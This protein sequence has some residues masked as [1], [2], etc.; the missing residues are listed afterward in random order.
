MVDCMSGAWELN[1]IDAF[2][3]AVRL[4]W[5]KVNAAVANS[6]ISLFPAHYERVLTMLW[7]VAH[8]RSDAWN[9]ENPEE[10]LHQLS[11]QCK[12]QYKALANFIRS[13]SWALTFNVPSGAARRQFRILCDALGLYHRVL[14]NELATDLIRIKVYKE[15]LKERYERRDIIDPPGLEDLLTQHRFHDHDSPMR[16]SVLASEWVDAAM[17]LCSAKPDMAATILTRIF[18]KVSN[19]GL[20]NASWALEWSKVLSRIDASVIPASVLDGIINMCKRTHDVYGLLEI[21][22][23]CRERGVR[24]SSASWHA[25]I[26]TAWASGLRH[27]PRENW[28]RAFIQV[29]LRTTDS[30][31][32]RPT[33]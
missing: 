1:A 11:G 14:P 19:Q 6:K 5:S 30:I 2:Y 3:S 9:R 16:V 13:D 24:L 32:P 10:Y 29:R 20:H 7:S 25:S 18:R 12:D 8:Y 23:V 21:L 22:Y 33:Y 27:L 17:G 28:S 31:I 4:E 26:E 15:G